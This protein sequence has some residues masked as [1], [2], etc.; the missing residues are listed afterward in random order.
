MKHYRCNK[1]GHRWTK[2]GLSILPKCPKC[3]SH[4]V[5]ELKRPKREEYEEIESTDVE[6]GDQ[7]Q[8]I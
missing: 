2:E 4:N 1:C 8:G 6:I 7:G 3:K 5:V